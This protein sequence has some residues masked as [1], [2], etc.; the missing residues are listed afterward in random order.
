MPPRAVFSGIVYVL[1]TGIPWGLLPKEFGCSGVDYPR[2]RRFLRRRG[3]KV[4]ITRRG[5]ESSERLGRWRWVVERTFSWI[6]CYRGLVVRYERRVD[7]H[8]TFLQLACSFV[9]FKRLRYGF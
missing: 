2:C 9:C 5:V 8:E 4:R 3:I 7:I 6:A 1:K